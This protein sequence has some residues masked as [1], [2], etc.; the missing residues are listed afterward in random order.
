[1][2]DANDDEFAGLRQRLEAEWVR[3]LQRMLDVSD[4][5]LP[6][7]WDADFLFGPADATGRDTYVLCEINVSCVSPFPPA[8][9]REVSEALARQ[10]DATI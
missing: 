9:P 8:A 3:G 2:R 10:L 4:E 5:E 1:M 7:L 6:L